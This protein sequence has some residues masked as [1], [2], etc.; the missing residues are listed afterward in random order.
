[1]TEI[2]LEEL[3]H[4]LKA[5]MPDPHRVIELLCLLDEPDARRELAMRPGLRSIYHELQGQAELMI[6][7]AEHPRYHFVFQW[8]VGRR[9]GITSV[10][11]F[12]RHLKDAISQLWK[13]LVKDGQLGELN[14][15]DTSKP[16]SAKVLRM[17]EEGE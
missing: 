8:Q 4:E 11:S 17:V 13:Q 14:E 10:A 16:A 12:T 15:I 1:M 7:Q 3:H 2:L 6:M 9:R 5:P